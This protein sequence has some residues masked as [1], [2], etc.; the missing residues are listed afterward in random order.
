VSIESIEL[1]FCLF[2]TLQ[3]PF[4]HGA[5]TYGGVGAVNAS[6][7]A[8]AALVRDSANI[9]RVHFAGVFSLH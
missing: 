7:D 4:S 6:W 2:L 9:A 8:M 3:D 1:K 5:Y